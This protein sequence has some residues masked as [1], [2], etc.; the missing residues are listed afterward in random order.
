[1]AEEKHTPSFDKFPHSYWLSHETPRFSHFTEDAQTEIGIV[2]GGIVGI[3][4][5]YLLVKA[6]RDVTLV[7]AREFLHG[8]T[9]HTT[10]K[11]SA[12]HGL[13]YDALI[14]IFGQEAARLYYDANIT[15]RDLIIELVK[16]LEIACDLETKDAVVFASSKKA[17]NKIK[18]EARAYEKLGIDGVL[19]YGNID[20]LPFPI[21]A[22][23]T[24]PA[25]AQFHPVKFLAFLLSEIKRLG[26]QVYEQTRAVQLIHDDTTILME[27]GAQLTCDKII[28]ASH[29][30]FNDFTGLYFTK[31]TISRSY[32]IATKITGPVPQAMYL[33]AESPSRSLRSI[34]DRTGDDWLLIG[35]NDHPTGK[36]K[37]PTL[38]HYQ[39]L[40]T[41]GRSWF[42]VSEVPYYWSAQDMMTL[43]Q[44]PYIGQMTAASK[45]IFLATGFNKWGMSTGAL[46]ADLLCD[47][48]AGNDNVYAAL[49][50]PT[51]SK[52]K[53][54]VF[55]NFIKNNA[56]VAK[57]F[58]VTKTEKTKKIAADLSLDE[59]ALVEIDNKK[60]GAYR[61][62][63][64][65]MHIVEATCTHLGCGLRWNEA[66]RSWDCPCHGSRFSHSGEVLNGPAVKPL[67]KIVLDK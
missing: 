20:E 55:H 47:L 36:S 52:I 32:A 7:E 35:G 1:M 5:A 51:R 28:V 66:E 53:S 3:M 50:D 18:A 64:G 57:D 67:K 19:A 61:D 8:V 24:M 63:D 40:E 41:F 15:G 48:I 6:G 46:A 23:L 54:K 62:G 11:I 37:K 56:G 38:T 13:I 22:S 44:V 43:D 65:Q 34:A 59:G 17:V 14:K 45:D 16:S 49:F 4:S 33:S 60:A 27:N 9:G 39:T 42:G 29:Y 21:D 25:Q 26:G 10:A 30:P 12:Q 31:L 58:I 2:G